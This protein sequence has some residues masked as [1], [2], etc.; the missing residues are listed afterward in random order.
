MGGYHEL[1]PGPWLRGVVE[2][3]APRLVQGAELQLSLEGLEIQ[4]LEVV[5]L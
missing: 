3:V 1:F 4:T 5:T 2:Y